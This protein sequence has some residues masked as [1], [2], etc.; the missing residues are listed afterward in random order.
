MIDN[1][2]VEYNLP[3][4]AYASFDAMSMK[5]LIIDKLNT[6]AIFRDQNYEGSNLN[7]IID[8]IA[9]MYH[10]LLFNLNQAASETV[11]TQATI[12][13]NMNKIVSLLNYKPTGQQTSLAEFTTTAG[14][15]LDVG[16]Y[17][18]RKFSYI[19]VNG[20]NYALVDD[21]SF[22]KTKPNEFETVATNN[23]NLVQGTV[24]E[25]PSYFATG[26]NFEVVFIAF[27]NLVNP[28]DGGF[29]ADNT[30]RVYVKETAD[31]KWYEY[32]ETPSLYL[33]NISDRVYE[34]RFNENG[35]Y[36]L[37]FGD[38]SNG[39]RLDVGDEVAVYFVVSDGAKGLINEGD[40]DGKQ[41][42]FFNTSRFNS[43]VAD[44]YTDVNLI[45]PSQLRF[46][47]FSNRYPST[48]ISDAETVD[49]IRSNAP[50]L[51]S[52]Q[53][54]AVTLNDYKTIVDKNFGYAIASS[55]AINNNV[56]VNN[57]QR[58]FYE[59]GLS[60]PNK[61]TS[62]LVNQFNFMTSTNFNNVY[63]FMVPRFGTIRNET[64]PVSLSV[65]QKQLVVNELNKVKSA[66]HEVVPMDPIYKAFS[67][68]LLQSGELPT[69]Q[70]TEQTVLVLKRSQLSTQSREKIK[71]DA[72]QVVSNYF[73]VD[74]CQL[75]QIVDLT[76]LSNTLLAVDGVGRILT[77]RV[78]PTN[79]F[80]VPTISMIYW[81]PNY[82]TVDINVAAQNIPLQVYEFP[83]FYQQSL[84]TNKI[85]V[86]DE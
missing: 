44:L 64:S 51:F 55:Q 49:Q 41:M 68:G 58:Y 26:E 16:P 37:K 12:Y 77:R 86:E 9:Y 24:T 22:E 35:R 63:I 46:L 31:N 85:I 67:F 59:L 78:T 6:N 81:N 36:E 53:N 13:E 30:I 57:Y 80:E 82:S 7:S 69:F 52:T 42:L 18:V 54:R 34:K 2:L 5:Q 79:T 47:S 21:L 45:T 20:Y 66:S 84:I 72:V 83:F 60:Q 10:V 76:K 38:N 48:P 40:L 65:A 33:N 50:K 61:D 23:I 4:N 15:Q 25:Y 71:N 74:N 19:P 75:G 1:N 32:T 3:K 39:K 56:Y 62:V 14:T 29:I 43:I 73:N 8:I 17:L 70:A 27:S 11:F 28:N